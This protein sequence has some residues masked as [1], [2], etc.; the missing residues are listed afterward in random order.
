MHVI[1]P[2][3]CVLMLLMQAKSYKEDLHTLRQQCANLLSESR[4]VVS[5]YKME[6]RKDQETIEHLD[7][8]MNNK[9]IFSWLI[10]VLR[11]VLCDHSA[12]IVITVDYHDSE[13]YNNRLHLK[14]TWR[15]VTRYKMRG[16]G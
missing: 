5:R 15:Y 13:Y 8:V 12:T 7:Q 2:A 4:E 16:R 3:V 10:F 14:H 1:T 9:C 6:K 11:I